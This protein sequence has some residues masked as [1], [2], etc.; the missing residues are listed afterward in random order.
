MAEPVLRP[1]LPFGDLDPEDA[2]PPIEEPVQSS[3]PGGV[4]REVG[5]DEGAGREILGRVEPK[6]AELKVLDVVTRERPVR[7]LVGVGVIERDSEP[8]RRCG[9][10]P[11]L[12][13]ERAPR[14]GVEVARLDDGEAG[15]ALGAE[16]LGRCGGE[17][18]ESEPEPGGPLAEFAFRARTVTAIAI[19]QIQRSQLTIWP[20][21]AARHPSHGTAMTVVQ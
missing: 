3:P 4:Q 7:E 18:Y 9:R 19:P 21:P 6:G 17:K 16:A 12:E 20:P 13:V 15:V 1:K 10:Y 11:G 14:E 5:G 8:G 2:V